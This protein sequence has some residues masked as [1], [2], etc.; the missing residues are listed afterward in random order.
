VKLQRYPTGQVAGHSS[1][2]L[3]SS[4]VAVLKNWKST[5]L[6]VSPEEL[7]VSA[8]RAPVVTNLQDQDTNSQDQDQD[9]NPQN[10]DTEKLSQ[11]CLEARHCLET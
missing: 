8:S 7:L 6:S 2:V 9:T 11:D 10:Q 1:V 3:A 5:V 4:L